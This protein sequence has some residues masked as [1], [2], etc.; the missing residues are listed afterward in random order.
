MSHL[1]SQNHVEKLRR[2][3]R[4][5]VRPSTGIRYITG[6][7]VYYKRRSDNTWKGPAA[8][9]G[10]ESQQVLVKHGSTYVRMHPCSLRLK[11]EADNFNID[12]Q[13]NQEDQV[14]DNS[15]TTNHDELDESEENN[16]VGDDNVNNDD[17]NDIRNVV[18]AVEENESK[19]S[20]KSHKSGKQA[21]IPKV[22]DKVKFKTAE[23]WKTGIMHS[24]A[25]KYGGKYGNWVNIVYED[26][27]IGNMD[28]SQI[29]EWEVIEKEI[30]EVLVCTNAVNKD[31]VKLEKE[32]EINNWVENKV[33]EEVVDKNQ[34]CISTKWVI[35]EK[36][37]DGTGKVLS[38]HLLYYVILTLKC[39]YEMNRNFDVNV[40]MIWT[41]K[42]LK[43]F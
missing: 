34:S 6:D 1:L 43:L 16:P 26:G 20:I 18:N 15:N 17:I 11:K 35:T 39:S 22:K 3:L 9:I 33:F 29:G 25:G 5:N 14:E 30:Q 7:Q 31:E 38:L 8:V 4:H 13:L 28:W 12:V 40:L 21:E 19:N 32:K 23:G 36:N 10:Q 42:F 41:H 37:V 24:R 2:A 27:E